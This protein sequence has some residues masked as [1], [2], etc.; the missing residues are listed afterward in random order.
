MGVRLLST[1]EAAEL[2]GLSPNRVRQLIS[3]GQIPAHRV[4]RAYVL[5]EE[6]VRCFAGQPPGRRGRPRRVPQEQHVRGQISMLQS[7]ENPAI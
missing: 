7:P 3:S 4:G 1:R 5:L 2:L 6:D